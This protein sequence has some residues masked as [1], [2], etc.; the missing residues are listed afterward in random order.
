MRICTLECYVDKWMHGVMKFLYEQEEKLYSFK[1]RL[2]YF[3]LYI[4]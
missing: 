3:V 4:A 2:Y 1:Q